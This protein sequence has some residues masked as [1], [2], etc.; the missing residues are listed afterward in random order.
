MRWGRLVVLLGI[1]TL[2]PN[3]AYAGFW[4]WLEELSGPG[5]FYGRVVS[6]PLLCV[7]DGKA[8]PCW[9]VIPQNATEEEARQYRPKR[10]VY[11]SVGRLGSRDN[12]RFKDLADTPENRREVHVLQISGLYMFRLHPSLD[13]GFGAGT[14]RFSGESD[15]D[16]R[17]L[18]RLTLIPASV[19]VRPLAL[20]G[21]WKDRW[22]AHL[23]RG[24][25]ET[26]FVTGGFDSTQ[27]GNPASKFKTGPEFLTRAAVVIDIG[28]IV[29]NPRIYGK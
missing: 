18:W 2:W 15:D 24:E 26:S 29:W 6:S 16:F 21:Q 28:S 3:L 14:L 17:P 19:S 7:S 8:V 4:A 22:F 11:L 5:P 12:L 25:I 20:V 23:V 27:F 10:L 13:A 1:I 9:R